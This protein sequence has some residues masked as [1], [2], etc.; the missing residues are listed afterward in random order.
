MGEFFAIA[1]GILYALNTM[2]AQRGMKNASPSTAM[3]IDMSVNLIIYFIYL[4]ITKSFVFASLSPSV[5]V[6]R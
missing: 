4:L 5:F 1:T 3:M 6:V 2:F